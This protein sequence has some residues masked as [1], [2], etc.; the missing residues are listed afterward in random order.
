MMS[1]QIVF[2]EM[3]EREEE[4]AVQNNMQIQA[5]VRAFENRFRKSLHPI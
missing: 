4:F 2:A 3:T 1:G 5:V